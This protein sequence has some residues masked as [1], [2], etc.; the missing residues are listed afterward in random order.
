VLNEKIA[1][2]VFLAQI[3]QLLEKTTASIKDRK[4]EKTVYFDMNKMPDYWKALAVIFGTRI[5]RRGQ[6]GRIA[7][8]KIQ[9]YINSSTDA[10]RQQDKNV[11]ECFDFIPA[12]SM[13]KDMFNSDKFHPIIEEVREKSLTST[14]FLMHLLFEA[15]RDGKLPTSQLIWLKMID[16]TLFFSLN[17]VTPELIA[18]GWSEAAG[19]YSQY[20][21]EIA[22][23]SYGLKMKIPYVKNA[24]PAFEKRLFERGVIMNRKHLSDEDSESLRVK[25]ERKRQFEQQFEESGGGSGAARKPGRRAH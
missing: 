14:T 2:K 6:E 9:D 1:E 13:F 3:P 16:R 22:A 12:A 17:S 24:I 10:S 4:I 8:Q 25:I 7:A 23:N 5:I 21:S 20:L 18:R 11:I 19:P 15:R